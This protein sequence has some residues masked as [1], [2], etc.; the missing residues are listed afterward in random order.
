M[1]SN[2]RLF[3][4]TAISFNNILVQAV[5]T[6][7]PQNRCPCAAWPYGIRQVDEFQESLNRWSAGASDQGPGVSA[8]GFCDL[9]SGN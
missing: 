3:S 2:A 8:G 1:V 5:Y 6:L 4:Q 7:Q 9:A